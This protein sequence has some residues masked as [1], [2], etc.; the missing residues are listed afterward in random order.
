VIN[1]ISKSKNEGKAQKALRML[2]RM[3]KL[4][5]AGNKEARPCEI[6]YT[7]VLNSCAFPAVLDQRTRRKALDTAIFTLKELQSSRYGQPNQVTYGTFM[8][9]CANLLRDDDEMR[10]E[11]IERAFQQ[12]CR[13]GQVGEMVLAYLRQAAPPDLYKKL[14]ADFIRS[15][16][17]ISVEDLPQEWR[18]NVK[19]KER[20]GKTKRGGNTSVAT[21]P[22]PRGDRSHN[23]KL[24][25][26]QF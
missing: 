9:A 19:S 20:G 7:A 11:V 22:D 13:D 6:T 15:G 18:C 8:K 23:M 3:D 2:R 4:Y 25:C 12:C 1:A 17:T 24:R 26:S 14:L 10:R 16:A 5:Q 21:A